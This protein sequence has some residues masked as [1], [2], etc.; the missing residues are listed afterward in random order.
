MKPEPGAPVVTSLA[1]IC[2]RVCMSFTT[3]VLPYSVYSGRRSLRAWV[4]IASES[5]P[6]SCQSC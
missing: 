1:I 5:G 2:L 6:V 4:A 3:V